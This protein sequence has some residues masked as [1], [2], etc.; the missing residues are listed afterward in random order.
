MSV[1]SMTFWS[2]YDPVRQPKGNTDHWSKFRQRVS[3]IISYKL[4]CKD[5]FAHIGQFT[6]YKKDDFQSL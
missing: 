3:D 5:L 2:R 4:Y 6:M 1:H